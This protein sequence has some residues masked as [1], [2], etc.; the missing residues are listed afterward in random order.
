MGVSWV[1]G[2]RDLFLV[3]LR[4]LD[5]PMT[6]IRMCDMGDQRI[7]IW[8]RGHKSMDLLRI[9]MEWF[10]AEYEAFDL[11]GKF[12]ALAFDLGKCVFEQGYTKEAHFNLVC[13]FGTLEHVAKSQ[14]MAFRHVHRLTE[15]RG[16]MVHMLPHTDFV[17][18]DWQ[19]DQE[20]VTRLAKAQG[21]ELIHCSFSRPSRLWKAVPID[22]RPEG[23]RP[24][25]RGRY[26]MVV[27]RRS[28]SAAWNSE[29]WED[30]TPS[31]SEGRRWRCAK[32]VSNE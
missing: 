26:C 19:Y 28:T 6:S 1:N 30:P 15:P 8:W 10:G 4:H 24:T 14:E 21:Y 18:G 25:M 22:C 7:R 29:G 13:N 32:H 16:I 9:P 31:P 11:N 12:G 3:G 27:M 2:A 5:E 23:D 20:W 17:H